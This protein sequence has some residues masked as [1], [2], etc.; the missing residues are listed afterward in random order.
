M[1]P[2]IPGDSGRLSPLRVL[3]LECEWT[4]LAGYLSGLHGLP[5]Y[6]ARVHWGL[7]ESS[8][9]DM[10]RSLTEIARRTVKGKNAEQT[11]RRLATIAAMEAYAPRRA[12]T[13]LDKSVMMGCSLR[14]WHRKHRRQYEAL[15]DEFSIALGEAYY[16]IIKTQRNGRVRANITHN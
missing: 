13:A 16:H 14:G 15:W 8:I 5:Y 7:D 3:S 4:E 10:E 1:Q 11:A 6:A 12:C 9:G 2:S